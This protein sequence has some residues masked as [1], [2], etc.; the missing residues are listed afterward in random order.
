MAGRLGLALGSGAIRG[1]AHIG[2]LKV[3]E[4]EGIP[5]DRI[6]GSS[7]GAVIGA[8][9]A[10]GS[11]IR[12]LEQLA[13]HM[14][15]QHLLEI[16]VPRLGLLSGRKIQAFLKLL[17][18][19]QQFAELKIP[20]AVVATDIERGEEVV[21]TEGDVTS[22]VRASISI[23]GIFRPVRRDGKLLVDGGV[24]APVPVAACRR[25]GADYVLAVDVGL[26]DRVMR[27]RNVFEVL[28]RSIE[29]MERESCRSQ[30]QQADV[31]IRPDLRGI[32]LASW[33]R[34]AEIIVAGEVA[35]E[36]A[37]PAVRHLLYA[38]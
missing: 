20:L 2:V 36:T 15:W 34:A 23:P 10:T 28:L 35:A 29:I 1:L 30:L 3:L 38:K 6:A 8:I 9:Y 11:D 12:M 13:I 19:R 7:M 14:K 24:M 22:A 21:I 26:P 25:L 5:I 32:G 33:E 18:K 31:V 17:I 37:L 16:S 27:V 4:R